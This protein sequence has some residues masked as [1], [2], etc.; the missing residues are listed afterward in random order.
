MIGLLVHE[1]RSE[2][3][4]RAAARLAPIRGALCLAAGLALWLASTATVRADGVAMADSGIAFPDYNT[5]DQAVGD[6]NGDSH[7]DVFTVAGAA[8]YIWINNGD[9]TFSAVPDLAPTASA[10]AI[11]LGDLD[12]DG[13]LDAYLGTSATDVVYLNDGAGTFTLK[14]QSIPDRNCGGVALGD[15][16]RD[17]DLDAVKAN[18]NQGNQ[19]LLNDG[20][21]TFADSGQSLGEDDSRDLALVDVDR[22]GDL[23]AVFAN[24]TDDPSRVYLN[25]GSGVF[26]DSGQTLGANHDRAVAAGDLDRDG[27]PD[28]FFG[29]QSASN[30]VY[31]NNGSGVFTLLPPGYGNHNTHGLRLGDLDNDGDLDAFESEWIQTN[32]VYVNNGSAGFAVAPYTLGLPSYKYEATSLGDLDND[33]D[34]DAYVG[35]V[36]ASDK[37]FR[38]QLIHRSALYPTATAIGHSQS[39]PYGIAVA[40]LDRDGRLDL[41][42]AS[43]SDD[44]VAWYPG[45][46]S[47]DGFGSAQILTTAADGAYGVAVG[48]LDRDGWVDVLSASENDDRIAWHK[49]NG[50]GSFGGIATIST[51]ANGAMAVAVGDIDGDGDLDVLSAS[52]IDNKFA[53]YENTD[54]AGTFGAQKII[55]DS[56]T[57]ARCIQPVDID[58]DGDLDVLY[59]SYAN[60]TVGW[61]ENTDGAGYFGDNTV[62]TTVAENAHYA[63]AADLDGDGDPDVLTASLA[64]NTIAWHMNIGGDGTFGRRRI[65]TTTAEA[66]QWVHAADVDN[67]GDNDVLYTAWSTAQVAWFENSNGQGVFFGPNP[68]G[69]TVNGARAV[70]T[71]DL[72]RDG[73]LDAIVTGGAA[74]STIAWFSNR[75]GQF[76][77]AAAD[78]APTTIRQGQSASVLKIDATHRGRTGDTP[79]QLQSTRILL[80]SAP[81]V[82]LTQTEAN[83][84]IDAVAVYVDDGSGV[85]E[86]GHDTMVVNLNTLALSDGALNVPFAGPAA[87]LQIALGTPHTYFIVV[88]LTPNAFTQTPNQFRLSHIPWPSTSGVDAQFQIPAALEYAETVVTKIIAAEPSPGLWVCY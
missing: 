1:A 8:A 58:R 14:A 67:D 43:Q 49:N 15:V 36:T 63:T 29:D 20:T 4:R 70:V 65:L 37:I 9:G 17:G 56:C 48:D 73:D 33:G 7:P 19:I 26:T 41:V 31:V 5:F 66:T 51:S 88:K 11:A 3:R 50:D 69:E 22:D 6:L 32:R 47:R 24:T 85:Y 10:L 84:L 30:T 45:N 38:N 80:E 78:V 21:A 42:V 34:I 60:N 18:I 59:A 57:G 61:F 35:V 13:D 77:Y 12:G 62:I 55:C 2:N 79:V 23:D 71:G 46:V 16:D 68:F 39:R 52:W 40:D 82:P 53:W 86:P 64:D 28:L 81:G 74:Q 54:G 44:T 87:N 76:A 25:N 72:D 27:D 83:A 75:G